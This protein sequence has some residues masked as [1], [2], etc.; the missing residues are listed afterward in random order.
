VTDEAEQAKESAGSE[1]PVNAIDRLV[2]RFRVPLEG[3]AAEASEIRGEFEVCMFPSLSPCL[4]WSVSQC[5]G[6]YLMHQIPPSSQ[7]F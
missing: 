7:I 1:N 4:P 3:A 6:S 5:G 2:E